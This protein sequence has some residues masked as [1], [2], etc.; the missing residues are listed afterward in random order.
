[1]VLIVDDICDGGGTFLGISDALGSRLRSL[2]D[3]GGDYILG[4]YVTHGIFSKGFCDL[5]EKFDHVYTT[6]SF[7]RKEAVCINGT[8]EWLTSYQCL[9]VMKEA[10]IKRVND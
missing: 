10:Y 9:P 7:N 1:V 4:L 3:V 6:D 5:I 2:G 8:T